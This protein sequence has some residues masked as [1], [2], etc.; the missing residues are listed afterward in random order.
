MEEDRTQTDWRGKQGKRGA[1]LMGAPLRRLEDILLGR[2]GAALL[3]EVLP[4]L[5]RSAVVLD[6]GCGSGYLGLQIAEK[7]DSGK[8]ICVDLS[9]E[10]LAGLMKRARARKVDDR[11]EAI[12]AAVDATGLDG[13]LVDL[14]VSNNLLHELFEPEAAIA[15]WER[16]LKPGGRMALSDFRDTRL[17][18]LMMNHEHGGEANEPFDTEGLEAVLKK[19]GLENVDVKPYRSKLL[20][21]ARKRV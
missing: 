3:K 8:V 11:I 6:A 13:E 20:A 15:E 10:M 18:K 12:K 4:S 19:A 1:F 5:D 17:T 7:L 21:L 16:L 9:D 2:S 14:V